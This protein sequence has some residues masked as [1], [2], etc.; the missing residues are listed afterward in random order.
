MNLSID[1]FKIMGSSGN[2]AWKECS[3]GKNEKTRGNPVGQ[4]DSATLAGR[5]WE[6]L[7]KECNEKLSTK[8]TRADFVLM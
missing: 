8:M 2:N 1:S 7:R 5:Y 6:E 3:V 4:W